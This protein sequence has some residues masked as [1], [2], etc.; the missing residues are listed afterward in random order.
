[1]VQA[2]LFNKFLHY[3]STILNGQYHFIF[4]LKYKKKNNTFKK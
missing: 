3:F 2:K 1:M 4:H